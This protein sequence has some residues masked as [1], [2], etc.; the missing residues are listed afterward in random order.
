MAD[1]SNKSKTP[2]RN[3][4]S[5]VLYIKCIKSLQFTY[6]YQFTNTVKKMARYENCRE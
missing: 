1:F 6:L 3:A 2:R 5:A 4:F